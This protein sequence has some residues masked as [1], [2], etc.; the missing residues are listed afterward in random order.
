MLYFTTIIKIVYIR[1]RN[2]FDLS[3]SMAVKNK[4]LDPIH[5]LCFRFL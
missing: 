2:V 4:I 3:G 1:G 5:R